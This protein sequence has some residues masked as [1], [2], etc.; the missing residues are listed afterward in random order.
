MQEF[1][2]DFHIHSKYSGGTSKNMELPLIAK[3]A[4]LKGLHLVGTG[5]A[6]NPSWM[7]H[8]KHNLSEEKEGGVYSIKKSMT[9]FL[10]TTEVE[11]YKRVHHVILFPS[12]SSAESLM[13]EFR[14]F[15]S[16]IERDGRP[17]L[18]LN[19]EQIVDYAK[20]AGALVG[21]AHAFTP[22][23]A[24]YK[25][26]DS[27]AGCYGDNMKEIKFLELGLSADTSMADRI[28]ELEDITFMT[29]SD[30]HSPW[31]HR[32]GREFNR[33]SIKEL[34]FNEIRKAIERRGD[35]KFILNV[36]LN[37]REGKYHLTACSRCFLR[38]RLEDAVKLKWRCPECRGLIKKGVSD[39]IN[40][41]ATRKKPLHPGHR[42]RYIHILPLAEV[43]SLATGIRTLSSKTIG[44]R[45]NKLVEKFGTEIKVLVD[46]KVDEIKK[47][48]PK[49]GKIID[50]F[51]TGRMRYV[52][53][54]G[55]QYG[56]PTLKDEEDNFYGSGQK[57]LIDF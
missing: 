41:L 46:I 50:R 31:P 32:L 44:D 15:S 24:M 25:E 1:N 5:D 20:E 3:Q 4:E 39:R 52:A 34:S 9:R 23:T 53:G 47:A 12:I 27:I 26:Y 35:G 28:P 36:G 51:R 57:S 19:G 48:D 29:N 45:W 13:E 49:V 54:G 43:I 18:R 55:G 37:P 16:D 11:D 42:P 14:H 56:R 7:R 10:V 8:M 22:W 6:L 40:E 2:V 38:F 21:P 33:V 17:H 30:A